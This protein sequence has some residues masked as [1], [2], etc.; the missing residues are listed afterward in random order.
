MSK[1]GRE[2]TS[3]NRKMHNLRFDQT[4]QEKRHKIG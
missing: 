4:I 2:T 3:E 1:I